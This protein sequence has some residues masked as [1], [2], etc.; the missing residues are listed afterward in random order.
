MSGLCLPQQVRQASAD[1][2]ICLDFA[3]PFR[4]DLI[5]PQ[6]DK[7]TWHLQCDGESAYILQVLWVYT[8]QDRAL[9]DGIEHVCVL[10]M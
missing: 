10:R 4:V 9:L 6:Y 3:W 1:L 7:D 5:E 8:V 2:C